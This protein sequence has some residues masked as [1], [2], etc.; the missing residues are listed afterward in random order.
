LRQF[1]PVMTDTIA[2]SFTCEGSALIGIADI[3]SVPAARGVLIV[4]GGPQYRVGSHRQF[5]LLGREL[6]A[7][8][9]PSMRFDHRGIGDS[10]GDNCGFADLDA[11]INAAINAFFAKVPSLREVVIWGLCDAASAAL[12]YAPED[13]R[14]TGVVLLN[15]WVRSEQSLA[16]SYLTQYYAAQIVSREF[17][18]RLFTGRL[19]ILAASRAFFRNLAAA[20]KP[21][22][23]GGDGQTENRQEASAEPFQQRMEK[24][25]G[26]FDGRALIILSGED[27]TAGE[28]MQLTRSR[29]GWRKSLKRATT[30]QKLLAEANHTFSRQAWREQVSSWTLDWIR[31]W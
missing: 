1:D 18:Q 11:D 12:L 3:P 15:P 10:E 6:A 13:D 19:G 4:V 7:N 28:F 17:W 14:V 22:A 30:E 2:F 27:L 23:S 16:R 20:L 26:R 24:Q 31:S 5:T 9:I 8:G 29:R 25:F 21:V